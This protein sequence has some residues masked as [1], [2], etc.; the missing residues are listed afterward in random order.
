MSVLEQLS[1]GGESM[2]PSEKKASEKRSENQA[3]VAALLQQKAKRCC[4]CRRIT[5]N[6]DIAYIKDMPHCPDCLPK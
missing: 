5:M 3:N 6:R 2:K 1:I 4:V